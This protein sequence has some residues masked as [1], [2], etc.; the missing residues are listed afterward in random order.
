[1]LVP[2]VLAVLTEQEL[3]VV[4]MVV[5]VAHVMMTQ[6]VQVVMAGKVLFVLFGAQVEL[7]LQQAQR[8]YSNVRSLRWLHRRKK[9]NFNRFHYV[10]I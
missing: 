6:T 8:M 2:E 4:H 5:A 9:K 10:K 1:V 3:P 7:I